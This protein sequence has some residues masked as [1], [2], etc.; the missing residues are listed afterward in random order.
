MSLLTD[1]RICPDCRALLDTSGT[2]TGCDLHLT[3]P[4]AAELWT[5]MQVADSLVERL[6]LQFSAPVSRGEVAPSRT[7]GL[8]AAPP[9]PGQPA[10]PRRTGLTAASV[11]AVLFGVGA[12]CL[13]VAAVVFVAVAWSSLGLGAR[14]SILLGV[15]ATFGALAGRLTLRGLRGAAETFWLVVG[16]LVT[17][18]LTAAYAAGLLGYDH[19]EGR[20]AVAVL[21]IALLGLG[22]GVGTW[23]RRTEL[24]G[25]IA[26]TLLSTAGALM[27]AA[28]EG[29]AAPSTAAG[30]AV[31]VLALAGLAAGTRALDLRHTAYAVSGLAVVSWTVLVG[32]GL[33]RAAAVDAAAWWQGLD[34]WPLLAAVL[35]AAAATFAPIAPALRTAAAAASELAAVLLILGPGA[36]QDTEIVV[37]AGLAVALAATSALTPRTWSLPA[38]CYAGIAGIVGGGYALVRPLDSLSGL[39]STGPRGATGFSQHLTRTVA[40]TSGWTAVVVAVAVVVVG[41]AL[42]RWIDDPTLGESTHRGLQVA[43]PTLVALGVVTA[44][45]ETGPT[46]LAAVAAW[47]GVLVVLAALATVVR[48]APAPAALAGATYLGVVGLRLAVPSHPLAALLATGLAVGLWVGY[49][50][51][52][53][54]AITQAVTGAAAL[55]AAGFAATHWPYL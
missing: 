45:L 37:L 49:R 32:A 35:L 20:H 24:A 13:L 10:R 2:C 44:F 26:P 34:C 27:V 3:G 31:A 47:T 1:S 36:S 12:L 19:L 43:A 39:P 18:D 52:S 22:V 50:R 14:T 23:V 55:V 41:L 6:R 11:P 21:G 48:G 51:T 15:T 8:P 7:G 46:V 53:A 29:W 5:T 16:A 28:G 30:A 9:L 38:A 4:L 17:I 25:L 54:D 42:L 40:D 33:D